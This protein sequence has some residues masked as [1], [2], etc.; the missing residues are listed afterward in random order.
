MNIKNY[1]STVPASRS[2]SKIEQLLIEAGATNIT[3]DIENGAVKQIHFLIK[4]SNFSQPILIRLPIEIDVVYK[5]LRD[6][7]KKPRRGTLDKL[8]DQ[9][10]RTAWKIVAD[11][12]EIQLT[13]IKF[14]QRKL[15][16]IFL[17]DAV[18]QKTNQTFFQ[19]IENNNYN[20][21]TQ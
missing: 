18:D 1:T 6:E 10:T 17:P 13:M 8:R 11:W 9:A 15:I 14:K 20:L 4:E 2:L 12:L 3:K 7:I 19:I 5:I 21:L 16:Q